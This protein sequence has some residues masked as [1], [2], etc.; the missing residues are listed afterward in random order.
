MQSES[1]QPES[2][3]EWLALRQFDLTSTKVP[4]LFGCNPYLTELD[5]WYR[6]TTG[7]EATSLTAEAPTW[8]RRLQTAIAN[9]AV[10]DKGWEIRE[11][12]EYM[13][14][15]EARIGSSFDFEILSPEAALLEI[16]NVDSHAFRDGWISEGNYLEAPPYIELQVQHQMLVSGISLAYI[17][18]LV[19][20]NTL[21]IIRREANPAIHE[22]ILK[23]C[24]QF[25][26]SVDRNEPP[27]PDFPRDAK[28]IA[29]IYSYAE[30][31]KT[32][33]SEE[34]PEIDALV[35]KYHYHSQTETAARKAK[36]EAKAKI[37]MSIGD[38]EKVRGDNYTISAGVI[39]PKH[40]EYERK[41]YRNFRIFR[42]KKNG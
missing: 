6:I 30:P 19:G 5:L 28:I 34:K 40:I 42:S 26:G 27:E 9:G 29:K 41:A 17:A 22:A 12:R 14:I 33:T 39:G 37:L 2:E 24:S 31:G 21:K 7:E 13:R 35:E 18:A 38:Y 8:G 15:P 36:D 11:K 4:A 32:M 16:K 23:R 20:G 10:A 1:V 25:W 3:K